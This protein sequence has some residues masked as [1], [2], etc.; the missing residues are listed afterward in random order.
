VCVRAGL[1]QQELQRHY[2]Q[3][4]SCVPMHE[5]WVVPELGQQLYLH[6]PGRL[7]RQDL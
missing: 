7:R 4:H 6:L 2:R 5:R 3:L 1:Y